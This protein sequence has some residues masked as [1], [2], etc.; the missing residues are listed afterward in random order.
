[1]EFLKIKDGPSPTDSDSVNIVTAVVDADVFEVTGD[2]F[3]FFLSK[4]WI[5]NNAQGSEVLLSH[6]LVV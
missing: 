1:M 5:E 3:F 2:F 6:L 4:A